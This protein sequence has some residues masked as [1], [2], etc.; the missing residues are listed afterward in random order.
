MKFNRHSL[1]ATLFDATSTFAELGYKFKLPIY[2]IPKKRM[3]SLGT[4]Q[5]GVTENGREFHLI[6]I[7]STEINSFEDLQDTIHHEL[8]HAMQHEK[9]LDVAHGSFFCDWVIELG[10]RGIN[11][12]CE[13]ISVSQLQ[14]AV[15]RRSNLTR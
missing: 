7:N 13:D 5:N 6:T 1:Q 4:W 9:G 12:G 11:T 3:S 15:I 2:I 8:I 10:S 14:E